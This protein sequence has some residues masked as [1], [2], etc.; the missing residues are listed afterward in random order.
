MAM[1]LSSGLWMTVPAG[2]RGQHPA[3]WTTRLKA[4]IVQLGNSLPGQIP[5]LSY[6]G[7]TTIYMYYGNP[8]VYEATERPAGV[9]DSNYVGVWHLHESPNDWCGWA[10]G[11][12][13]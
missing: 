5:T 6:N 12:H 2:G 4:L 10:C 3:T 7:D 1:T 9:W 8:S 13:G 11:F